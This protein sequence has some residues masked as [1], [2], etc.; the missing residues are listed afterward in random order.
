MNITVT[1]YTKGEGAPFYPPMDI[2]AVQDALADMFR[3]LRAG[4]DT[5]TSGHSYGL[6]TYIGPDETPT[7]SDKAIYGGLTPKLQNFIIRATK[8]W[9]QDAGMKLGSPE[10]GRFI[11]RR[12]LEA[13]DHDL[14]D[15]R[16]VIAEHMSEDQFLAAVTRA[17]ET[18][19]NVAELFCPGITAS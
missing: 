6:V 14:D 10:H 19:E 9:D 3:R 16:L 1:H 13:I 7:G 18:G 15:A 2:M 4:A 5:A 8:W 17:I 12:L 11:R